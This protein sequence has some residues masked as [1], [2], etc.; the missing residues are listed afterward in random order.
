MLHFLKWLFPFCSI[1]SRSACN[2]RA[3]CR[4][5]MKWN[6]TGETIGVCNDRG[7]VLI[8]VKPTSDSECVWSGDEFWIIKLATGSGDISLTLLV[9]LV[10][11]ELCAD[12]VWNDSTGETVG[13][14]NDRG[15]VL[16]SVKPASDSECVWSGDEFWI[17]K[18][19]TGSGDISS[20]DEVVISRLMLIGSDETCEW[21]DSDG[22][23]LSKGNASGG[24]GIF[25]WFQLL[26]L[27]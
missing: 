19:A 13:V 10:I 9:L 2:W 27:W 6:S 22:K 4:W 14:C 12:D 16:I 26:H 5:C 25:G 20:T 7:G 18:L 8:S 11:G 17:L 1:D 15:G 21:Y 3:L 23:M 24:S